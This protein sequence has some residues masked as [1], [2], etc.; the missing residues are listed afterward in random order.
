MGLPLVTCCGEAFAG[1]VSASLLNAIGL[2][3]LVTRSLEEYE[4]LAIRLASHPP[5]LRELRR[6]LQQNLSTYPL[7][8]AKRY[9]NH[10]EAAYTSM[11]G[12]WQRGELPR[13][14]AVEPLPTQS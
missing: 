5:M 1:R 14:F 10:I 7:F 2:P 13:S 3:E 8:D 11:W 4:S 6:K 12:L 9:R